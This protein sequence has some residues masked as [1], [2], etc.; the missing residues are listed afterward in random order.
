[1]KLR[2]STDTSLYTENVC[3]TLC[4]TAKVFF[5]CLQTWNICILRMY[6]SF[7]MLFCFIRCLDFVVSSTTKFG[8]YFLLFCLSLLLAVFKS[9]FPVSF[10]RLFLFAWKHLLLHFHNIVT[11]CVFFSFCMFVFLRL[12]LLIV[13]R[14]IGFVCRLL[15]L[16]LVISVYSRQMWYT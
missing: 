1:M 3:T 10:S 15:L 14:S 7:V 13:Y 12:I 8:C 4:H 6:I 16:I 9:L 5:K 2:E 11:N